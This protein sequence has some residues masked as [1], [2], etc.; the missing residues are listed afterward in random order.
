VSTP[1]SGHRHPSLAGRAAVSIAIAL[2]TGVYYWWGV[3]R[4]APPLAGDFAQNWMAARSVL[5]GHNPVIDVARSGWGWPLYY[6]MPAHLVSMAFAWLPF[7][8]AECL[9]VG[10]GAGLLAFGMS[11]HA[12]WGLL[13]FLTPSFLHAYFYAQ[14]SPLLTGAML[15]PVLGGLL[16][17]TPSTGLA[18]FFSRPSWKGALG[19]AI[20]VGACFAIRPGW[21]GEWAGAIAGAN[22]IIP[23]VMRPGGF[24]L[25]LA[26]PFWRRSDARLLLGLAL[27]PHRTLFYETVPLFTI[28]RTFRQMATLVILAAATALALYLGPDFGPSEIDQLAGQWPALLAGLYLPALAVAL[29]NA[30]AVQ[31]A[32]PA[33]AAG[34][35]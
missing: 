26:L 24:L 3:L 8:K 23:P 11:R 4:F 20:V 15:I 29:W 18:Y 31:R 32:T 6:P 2:A 27:V 34:T 22:A 33:S 28:P 9:F 17:A 35:E 14:W 25:L 30:R 7:I 12:W 16:T 21:V 19:A 5:A 13:I 1:A 10:A